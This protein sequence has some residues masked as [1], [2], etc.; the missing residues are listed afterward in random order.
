MHQNLPC[1]VILTA[2]PV[3]YMAVRAH[4]TNLREETH[5]QG[6]IYERGIFAADDKSWE[7]G[8]AEVGAGNSG[9]AFEAE[10]AI[11]YF[12]PNVVLFV[13]VAGGI[14][15]VALGD[16]VAATKVYGY[17]SGKT[18]RSFE[19]R[20]DVGESTYKMI[21]R[22]KAE[23]R[24]PEWLQRLTSLIPTPP[25]SVKVAP[26][27]AGG[28][29]VASTKSSI[30]KFLRSNYGDAVAVEME[31]RGFLEA[32]HANQE[33]SALIIRG[34]SDLIEG[35]SEADCAGFQEIAA[36][37]ASAFAFQIL[38]KLNLDK[39]DT[40]Q[41]KQLQEKLEKLPKE[42]ERLRTTQSDIESETIA[43]EEQ[44]IKQLNSQIASVKKQVEYAIPP[45]F[46][47]SIVWLENRE[48]LA[49]EAGDHILSNSNALRKI[50]A[51]ID[52]PE[53]AITEFYWIIEKYLDRI[54]LSLYTDSIDLLHDE[55]IPLPQPQF[56]PYVVEAVRHIK[57][58]IPENISRETTALR[59][60]LQYIIDKLLDQAYFH[61]N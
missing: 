1:A 7:V 18:R 9:A 41:L 32:A 42:V 26:I 43:A 56:I 11:N 3:E 29:V 48:L 50:L 24:K 55:D 44:Q 4:L 19:P 30:Y 39:S 33:V 60:Y 36:R 51:D 5:S 2:I 23:A 14:K 6:T 25:P 45:Q 54:Y 40:Q 10:R 15:D 59:D 12:K 49:Q 27:A 46:N 34:I 22:S 37:H 58:S 61:L 20:P 21:Q 31:G 38:A 28:K 16:V 53:D 13:G 52:S 17:E 35:K 8:I 47:N 57:Q